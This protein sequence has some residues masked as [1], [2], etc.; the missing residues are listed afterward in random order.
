MLSAKLPWR[1]RPPLGIRHPHGPVL[2]F[3][4]VT[5][6]TTIESDLAA[7]R[8]VPAHVTKAVEIASS[9]KWRG[10]F[11]GPTPGR[12]RLQSNCHRESHGS[13]RLA[14]GATH[15]LSFHEEL[16]HVRRRRGVHGP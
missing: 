11:M 12:G 6:S 13:P 15:S 10:K 3:I 8:A 16:G 9:M 14:R 7:A 1:E 4:S 5:D 2:P